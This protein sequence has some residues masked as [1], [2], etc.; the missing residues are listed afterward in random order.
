[1][2]KTKKILVFAYALSPHRGSEYSVAWN[3]LNEMSKEHRL[4][5]LYGTNGE[6][7]GDFLP[8]ETLQQFFPDGRVRFIPV[9]PSRWVLLLNV[10]NRWKICCYSFYLAYHFW[11][12]SVFQ[13]VQKLIREEDFDLIHYLGPIGYREPGYLWTLPLPYIWGPVAGLRNIP[14]ALLKTLPFGGRFKLTARSIINS[15]Q[16]MFSLRVRKAFAQADVVLAA[17]QENSD[18]IWKRYHIKAEYIPENGIIGKISANLKNEKFEFQK[19]KLIWV[20][21]LDANKALKTLLDALAEI[22]G[23]VRFHLDVV[24]DGPLKNS[25]LK[26]A[27]MSGLSDN[28]TWHGHVARECVF[29]LFQSEHVHII[30]SCNEGNPTVLFEAMASGIPTISL[31]HCGMHDTLCEQCGIRIPISNYKQIVSELGNCIIRLYHHPEEV[32]RLSEGTVMCAKKYTWDKRREFFNRQY[33]KAIVH[34]NSIHN[35][36][37]KD[38]RYH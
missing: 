28:I 11:Q 19:I 26:Y 15:Y 18:I 14:P 6:H 20:G 8:V 37:E 34:Y 10:L 36:A 1:M 12:N 29:N 13:M 35:S 3:Y 25:L 32:K 5:V 27:E 7:L 23:K 31:D 30:T 24:G 17:T 33:D 16:Q 21:R 22:K 38:A 9:P 4:T 2:K